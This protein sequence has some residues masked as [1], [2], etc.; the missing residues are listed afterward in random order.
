MATKV[1]SL[2]KKIK[3]YE[4]YIKKKYAKVSTI[5]KNE[6]ID[7]IIDEILKC[8][9]GGMFLDEEELS[10]KKLEA[11]TIAKMILRK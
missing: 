5:K 7:E 2:K 11:A 3:D 4:L 8:N 9:E 10:F 1:K 6:I